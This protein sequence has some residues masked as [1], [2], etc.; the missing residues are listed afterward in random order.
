MKILIAGQKQFGADVF[1]AVRN[2]PG[3][4][5][6]AVSSPPEDRLTGQADLYGVKVIKAGTL[7]AD[8][9]PGG[10]DLIV[11]AH[12]HDFIGGRTRLRALLFRKALHFGKDHLMSQMASVKEADAKDEGLVFG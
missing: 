6:A 5:I 1:R 8:N 7:N 11:A 12:S 4:E 3:V 2:L 9:M 10:I